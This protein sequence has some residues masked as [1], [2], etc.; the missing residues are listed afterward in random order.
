MST[1]TR[2]T[3][4]LIALLP[5]A[6]PAQTP[7]ASPDGQF[8]IIVPSGWEVEPDP[9]I[10]NLVNFRDGAVTVAILVSQQH[11]SNA[12]SAQQFIDDNQQD[13]KAQC[14]TFQNRQSGPSTLLGYP[15]FTAID[16]CSDPRS[17]PWPRISPLS[18]PTTSSSA[19]PSSPHS[20]ATMRSSRSSTPFD[21]VSASPTIPH[22]HRPNTVHSAP[23]L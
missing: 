12:V 13:L 20:P 11:K 1:C 6:A 7:Y 5:L 22:P 3:L 23:T 19:S 18:P 15:A 9:T 8:T 21:P 16:T 2:L 10:S 4:I 14:P 17:P